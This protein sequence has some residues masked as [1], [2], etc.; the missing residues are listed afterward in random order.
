MMKNYRLSYKSNFKK[1]W[2][3]FVLFFAIFNSLTIPFEQAFRPEF[4]DE[5]WYRILNNIIDL[6]FVIDVI[7]MFF[8]SFL[9][10]VGKESFD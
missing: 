9:S 5:V 8:T 10:K 1:K 6:M 7:M 4:T 3:L 2:D